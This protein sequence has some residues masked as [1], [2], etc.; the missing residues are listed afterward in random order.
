VYPTLG[1]L[2]SDLYRLAAQVRAMVHDY[3]DYRTDLLLL[4]AKVLAVIGMVESALES[5]SSVDADGATAAT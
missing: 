2:S 1:D 4:N 3:P 5:D